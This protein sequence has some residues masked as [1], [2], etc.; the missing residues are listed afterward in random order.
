MTVSLMVHI[1]NNLP[2][3][4][5]ALSPASTDK[6]ERVSSGSVPLSP[7]VNYTLIND[8]LRSLAGDS[9]HKPS[10]AE[11]DGAMTTF[12]RE[13]NK[14]GVA[15][16]TPGVL[17]EKLFAEGQKVSL[18]LKNA[19]DGSDSAELMQR[20]GLIADATSNYLEAVRAETRQQTLLTRYSLNQ[21]QNKV[22][23]AKSGSD[24]SYVRMWDDIASGINNIKENY[25]DHYA[26]LMKLYTDMY[27]SFNSNV[28]KA[29]ADAVSTSK[30]AN[31]IFFTKEKMQK[32]YD[33]FY[34]AIME[35]QGK[36]GKVPGWSQ[37]NSSARDA[38]R[39]TYAPAFEISGDGTLTFNT[40]EYSAL[41]SYPSG[42]NTVGDVNTS[43][44][45]AWNAALNAAATAFQSNMQAFAQRYSQANNTFDN[46]NKVLSN[47]ISALA[48][49][50][51]EALKSLS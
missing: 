46:L 44:Y 32:G 5:T 8:V 18:F 21:T 36:L 51:K 9:N 42:A 17:T 6:N 30:D 47:A 14:S 20:R 23:Q 33:A 35:L 22:L 11:I 2:L 29:S 12:A 24:D 40:K 41:P 38:A 10:L 34:K 48:E 31:K 25:V 7:I 37:M 4:T 39:I 43:V 26:K 13:L 16:A 28:Q 19:A 45:Q 50:A 27:A 15:R 49:V 3:A 1:D